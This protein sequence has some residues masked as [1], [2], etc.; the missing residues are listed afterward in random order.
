MYRPAATFLAGLHPKTILK[1]REGPMSRKKSTSSRRTSRRRQSA[2]ESYLRKPAVQLGVLAILVVVALVLILGGSK[3]APNPTIITAE[4]A[5]QKY[6]QGV[7]LLD[8]R[9]PDEWDAY[10]I[11]NTTLIPLGQLEQRL[12]ELPR[13]REI[14]VVCHSG[15][16]S[17]QGATILLQNGFT[18][19]SSMEGGLIGWNDLGYPLEGNQ[20]P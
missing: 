9:E 20:L 17:K 16:R 4:T 8:V 14:V 12:N 6:Q 11:P 18:Q 10:H 5:Y 19:V 1:K 3:Q 2:L 13:D 7:F 15:N